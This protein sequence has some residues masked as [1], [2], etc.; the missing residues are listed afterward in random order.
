ML[1][2]LSPA[3][4]ETPSNRIR[5]S[6]RWEPPTLARVEVKA[7]WYNS[8]RAYIASTQEAHDDVAA[9]FQTELSRPASNQNITDMQDP[10]AAPGG[11]L[12]GVRSYIATT[13]EATGKL[14]N[15]F[16]AELGHAA[17]PDDTAS[18]Q[19]TLAQ[20]QSFS[21]VRFNLASSNEFINRVTTAYQATYN[22]PPAQVTVQIMQAL[23][24]IGV[25]L[26]DANSMLLNQ[27]GVFSPNGVEM[28]DGTHL[29]PGVSLVSNIPPQVFTGMD[30]HAMLGQALQ[31][32]DPSWELNTTLGGLFGVERPDI[33]RK[34][35]ATNA[36]D[37]WEL[38]PAGQEAVRANQLDRYLG[39]V[40]ATSN[41]ARAGDNQTVLDQLAKFRQANPVPGLA[42]NQLESNWFAGRTTYTI[43]K[44]STPGVLT[45]TVDN[46]SL[47][48][49]I[50]EVFR[51]RVPETSPLPLLPLFP[52]ALG[53]II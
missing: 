16:Q 35:P 28:P 50:A 8:V 31:S 23:A 21:N 25:P 53:P 19:A 6:G 42:P 48:K 38:K 9:A 34:N 20:G 51:K 27:T 15:I 2:T 26:T 17:Q 36:L 49:D 29:L 5:T 47:W 10:L 22:Q 12:N 33:L 32:V 13:Q 11:S 4:T 18:M 46:Q 45:Y 44:T 41:I 24:D 43:N 7:G 3:R 39:T 14:N 1:I 37:V 40:N 30:A 52:F